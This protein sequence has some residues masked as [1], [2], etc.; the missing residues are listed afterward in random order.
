M[1]RKTFFCFLILAFL[2]ITPVFAQ[3]PQ[4]PARVCSDCAFGNKKDYCVKCG[5][6]CPNNYV[7]ARLCGTC[8][9]GNKKDYCVKCGRWCP[10][11]YSQA[12][13]CSNCGFGNNKEKCV[14]CGNYTK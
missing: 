10:N 9:F 12:R 13:L 4:N 14:K 8:S 3:A 11:N 5:R 6:W 2:L 1:K 7:P